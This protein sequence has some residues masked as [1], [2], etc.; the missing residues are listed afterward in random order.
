M[1]NM[2][3]DIVAHLIAEFPDVEI[4]GRSAGDEANDDA[5]AAASLHM[6]DL[7][8]VRD[9]QGCVGQILSNRGLSILSISED[10]READIV[11]LDGER[12]TLDEA[13]LGRIAARVR[14]GRH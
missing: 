7:L 9:Q 8:I 3:G 4:V 14:G 11:R 12:L 5:L 1:P 6:A 13:S 10:G 2:L